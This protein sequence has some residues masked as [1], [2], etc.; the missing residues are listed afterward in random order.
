MRVSLLVSRWEYASELIEVLFPG[1]GVG[2][3]DVSSSNV[4]CPSFLYLTVTTFC[5]EFRR[6]I[7][8]FSFQTLYIFVSKMCSLDGVPIMVQWLTNL[9]SMHEDAGP[10]PGLA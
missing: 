6:N 3:V 5:L 1:L 10:I 9:T 7:F 4:S 8:F 2:F